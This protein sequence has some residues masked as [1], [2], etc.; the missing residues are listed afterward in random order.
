MS[1]VIIAKRLALENTNT[2]CFA[3][4]NNRVMALN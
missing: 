1:L 4:I 3:V 2:N